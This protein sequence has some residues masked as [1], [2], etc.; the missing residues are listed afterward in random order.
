MLR[1]ALVGAL[2][3]EL[4]RFERADLTTRV[5]WV[6]DPQERSAA[7]LLIGMARE[8]SQQTPV[9]SDGAARAFWEEVPDLSALDTR[10]QDS[11]TEA[12]GF[13]VGYTEAMHEVCRRIRALA[14]PMARVVSMRALITGETGVGKELVA[15]AVHRLGPGP[16][17]PFIPINCAVI[18]AGLASSELFGHVR[19]AF[20]GAVADRRGAFEQA[21]DGVLFLDEI[22][23]MALDVQSHLLRALEEQSFMPVGA[24]KLR[25]FKAQVLSATHRPLTEK[26]EARTFRADLYFRIAQLTIQV[27][28]LSE[29]TDD[30]QLL[31]TSFWRRAG[32]PMPMDADLIAALEER[33]W[34]GNIRELRSAVERFLVFRAT[35]VGSASS[36]LDAAI[37]RQPKASASQFTSATKLGEQRSWL[38]RELLTTVMRRTKWDTRE[39]AKELGVTRRTVY[40][41]L[42]RHKI[43]P[44]R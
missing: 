11:L 9:A 12:Y 25:R 41:L 2:S 8:S 42:R 21:G 26:V 5:T 40:N 35:G 16:S 19:G 22:G 37:G 6:V 27:P 4:Q 39:A 7:D 44:P 3:K 17:S 20:S 24:E 15:A 13:V 32:Q 31:A 33:A 43:K 23:E 30:I 38:E 10:L 14:H 29:R 18:P 1:V 36:I 34:P 28:S